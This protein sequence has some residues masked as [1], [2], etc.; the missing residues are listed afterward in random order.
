MNSEF[1]FPQ[2]VRIEPTSTC[3]LHCTHC[4]TGL[5]KNHSSRGKMKTELFD[6]ILKELKGNVDKIFAVVVY[7]GGEPL[8]N[9]Q[10]YSMISSLKK[11]KIKKVKMNTNGMLLNNCSIR[12]IVSSGLDIMYVSIDGLSPEENDSIRI[13]GN[14]EKIKENIFALA[15]FKRI[16]N[17]KNP[18]IVICNT[19]ILR[20]GTSYDDIGTPPVPEF[21]ARDFG[22][23]NVEFQANDAIIWPGAE[24][25]VSEKYDIRTLCDHQ[26][27]FVCQ[28]LEETITI[29]H[30]GDI[31]PCCYDIVSNYVAGNIKH[32]TIEQIWNSDRMENLRES[33]KC[34]KPQDM[35]VGCKSIGYN[36]I[37]EHK[38]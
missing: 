9:T 29:R 16:K 33:I 25:A 34:G 38:D 1:G 11:I 5:N 23:I 10:I 15:E 32:N 17:H 30:N 20:K 26:T 12:K 6:K 27:K 36:K 19:R 7:H 4:P 24:L 35:C 13:G 22:K 3:N 18:I 2:V 8:M 31:V 14:Y 37:L 21:L 28:N